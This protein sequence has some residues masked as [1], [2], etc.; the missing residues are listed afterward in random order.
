[1]TDRLPRVWRLLGLALVLGAAGLLPPAGSGG[2]SASPAAVLAAP[3]QADGAGDDSE[4][5]R[6]LALPVTIT[7]R[8]TGVVMVERARPTPSPRVGGTSVPILLY[9][10][11]RYPVPGDRQGFGLS[12]PPPMFH[13]QMEYLAANG[14]HVISLHDAVQAV[15]GRQR[16]P[17]R[18]VV[19]TF[20]DGYADFF[21]EVVP[22][23]R[24]WGF[25]ATSF[26]VTGRVGWASYMTWS[27]IQAA[28]AMGF[29]IGA[30]TV[31]HGMLTTLSPAQARWEMQQSRDTLA[32]VLGHPILDFAYPYGSFNDYDIATA[33]DLG[34]EC[35]VSTIG[36]PWHWRDELHYMYRLR[37]G[38]G[39][40]MY[41]FARWVGGPPYRPGAFATPPPSVTPSPT[42]TPTPS[43]SPTASPSP[44]A[45]S[46]SP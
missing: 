7:P 34:F 16:L 41:D 6:P 13:Q 35:A 25:T 14:F 32:A 29:T 46:P 37:I 1:M 20:D 11:I 30:H 19:L 22:E 26:V 18:P 40:T 4:L 3:D 2:R 38:G 42:P 21:T 23:L 15:L 12:V 10:Y 36:S 5:D 43:P 39:F 33:R 44:I 31:H 28:D 45:P 27:E 8:P 9:H 17:S 24:Y